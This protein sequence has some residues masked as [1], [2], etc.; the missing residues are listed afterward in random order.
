MESDLTPYTAIP[1]LPAQAALVLAPHPDDE[2]FGC[3]GAI[4][5]HVRAGVPVFVVI[6]T[7]GARF[8]E[9]SIRANE[10]RAAARV[11]GYGEPDF[12]SLADRGLRYSEALVQRIVNRI[13]GAGVD[14]VYAPSPWE[15]HPDHRQTAWLAMEAARRVNYRV[16]LA[17]YEV[18]AP[19]RPNVL[20]DITAFL[21]T[22]EAAMR[23]FESQL[24]QQ[25]YLRHIQAPQPIPHLHAGE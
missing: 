16:R 23:C 18:G 5:S 3:G 11:L 6:L 25:D 4:A 15:I 13:A 8:G 20:L 21:D 22:K 2:V 7:D 17:F 12:W 19:L 9:A 1:S 14:L 24:T 10:C